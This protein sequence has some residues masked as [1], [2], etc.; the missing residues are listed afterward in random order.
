MNKKKFPWVYTHGTFQ[1]IGEKKKCTY[2]KKDIKR[3]YYKYC[4]VNE[5][6]TQGELLPSTLAKSHKVFTIKRRFK[7]IGPQRIGNVLGGWMFD[8]TSSPTR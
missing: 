5:N 6:V 2:C 3:Q 7:F 1:M 4:Q 8:Y